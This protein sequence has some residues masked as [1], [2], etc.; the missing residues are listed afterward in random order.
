M[1]KGALRRLPLC[2]WVEAALKE[3]SLGPISG[4]T[5][6]HALGTICRR[7]RHAPA[8]SIRSTVDAPLSGW[9]PKG[10]YNFERISLGQAMKRWRTGSSGSRR[11][12][13]HRPWLSTPGRGA[14]EQSL[15]TM[16]HPKG[17]KVSSA[18]NIC[19]RSGPQHYGV[20]GISATFRSYDR[21]ACHDGAHADRHC[22]R[23]S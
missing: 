1:E 3:R 17:V 4:P 18:S 14:Q 10:S 7:G 22:S 6:A 2:C 11:S 20:R 19:S 15:C 23:I 12:Q 9:G 8:S 13:G 21:A 5:P 16:F